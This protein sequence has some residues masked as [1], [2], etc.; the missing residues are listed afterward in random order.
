MARCS[1]AT[2]VSP[3][4][5]SLNQLSHLFAFLSLSLQTRPALVCGGVVPSFPSFSR[6]LQAW[7]KLSLLARDQSCCFTGAFR[8]FPFWYISGRHWAA[9]YILLI[10]L[11]SS[12]TSSPSHIISHACNS[13]HGQLQIGTTLQGCAYLLQY[14]DSCHLTTS[15]P[16]RSTDGQRR[17]TLLPRK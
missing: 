2:V 12:R 9:S 13:W 5:V 11:D 8:F 6:Y 1:P 14:C 16:L 7:G 15:T 4:L 17:Q 3:F 10:N